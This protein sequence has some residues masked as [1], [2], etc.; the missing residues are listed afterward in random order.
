MFNIPNTASACAA[1]IINY[2]YIIHILIHMI[3][4]LH[5]WHIFQVQMRQY[6]ITGY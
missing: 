3:H 4:D 5:K 6:K 1:Y 2:A